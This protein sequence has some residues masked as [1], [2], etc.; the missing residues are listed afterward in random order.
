MIDAL[1]DHDPGDQPGRSVAARHH[2]R[3]SGR[4]ERRAVAIQPMPELRPHD[5]PLHRLG[6][7]LHRLGHRDMREGLRRRGPRLTPRGTLV[8]DPLRVIHHH[9]RARLLEAGQRQ[10][11]LG[12]IEFLALAAPENLLL[13]PRDLCL[14][15]RDPLRHERGYSAII[16]SGVGMW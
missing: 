3:R 14:Q 4:Q 10:L 1:T 2:S 7:D 6:H 13:E 8:G 15:R 16:W 11:A 12:E 9:R 5:L